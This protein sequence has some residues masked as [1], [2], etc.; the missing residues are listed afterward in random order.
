M[1]I[2]EES[3]SDCGSMPHVGIFKKKYIPKK[4]K[5]VSGAQAANR[6]GSCPTAPIASVSAEAAQ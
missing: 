4:Q 6:G 3:L 2:V 1:G 5:T